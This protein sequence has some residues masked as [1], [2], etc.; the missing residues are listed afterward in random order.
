MK[1][2]KSISEIHELLL[3]L[4]QKKKYVYNHWNKYRKSIIKFNI[5]IQDL[6]NNS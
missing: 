5:K 4:S 1:I 6:K 3:I 2:R